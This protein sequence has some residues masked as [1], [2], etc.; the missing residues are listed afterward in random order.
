M[1]K[2][3]TDCRLPER[4]EAGASHPEGELCPAFKDER[5]GAIYRSRRADGSCA[6]VHLWEGLPEE[7][8]GG[9]DERGSIT[10]LRPGVTP[11]YLHEGRFLTREQAGRTAHSPPPSGKPAPRRKR[12]GAV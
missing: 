2:R 7:L 1:T 3:Y 6:P 5:S 12:G 9:R 4:V 10:H 8:I 11:G